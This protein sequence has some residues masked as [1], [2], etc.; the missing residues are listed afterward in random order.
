M[1][2]SVSLV[3]ALRKASGNFKVQASHASASSPEGSSSTRPALCL[4]PA[5]WCLRGPSG[6]TA[7]LNAARTGLRPVRA[8]SRGSPLVLTPHRVR[9]WKNRASVRSIPRTCPFVRGEAS[10]FRSFKLKIWLVRSSVV[11]NDRSW[12]VVRTGPW[13]RFASFDE[14]E[15]RSEFAC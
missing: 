6:G 2:Q 1:N 10:L 14:K 7:P 3:L 13:A 15:P 4:K 8:K 5:L 12:L 11:W 9:N